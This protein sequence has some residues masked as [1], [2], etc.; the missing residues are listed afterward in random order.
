M[1]EAVNVTVAQETILQLVKGTIQAQLVEALSKDSAKV[2]DSIVRQTLSHT[3]EKNYQ[4]HSVI[5]WTIAQVIEEE[6]KECMKEWVAKNREKIRAAFEKQLTAK[7]KGATVL[8]KA[9]IDKMCDRVE[10][11][12]DLNIRMDRD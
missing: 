3:V 6:V 12:L 5:D 9:M 8:A 10:V 1:A 4:R 2:I 11:G 7:N